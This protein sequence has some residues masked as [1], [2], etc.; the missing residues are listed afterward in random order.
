M[1]RSWRSKPGLPHAKAFDGP[2]WSISVE[3][4]FYLLF[5]V[6]APFFWKLN[7][8]KAILAGIA[9]YLGGALVVAYFIHAGTDGLTANLF[10]PWPH[11]YLHSRHPA[12]QGVCREGPISSLG[13]G[14]RKI[15]RLHSPGMRLCLPLRSLLQSCN[16]QG[17]YHPWFLRTSLCLGHPCSCEP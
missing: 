8:S 14:C 13:G 3:L 7:R 15:R 9:S 5:P 11:L 10:P 12:C 1:C 6:F 16:S 2:S 4:F 17:R